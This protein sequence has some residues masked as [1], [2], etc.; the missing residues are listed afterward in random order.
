MTVCYSQNNLLLKCTIEKR[1]HE[2]FHRR[3][4]KTGKGENR[5]NKLY[6]H[7]N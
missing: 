5:K 4:F 6:Y 3:L 1:S 7:L 2:S